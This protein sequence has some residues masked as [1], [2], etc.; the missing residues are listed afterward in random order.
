MESGG[1]ERATLSGSRGPGTRRE[2]VEER[3]AVIIGA[4]RALFL[5]QGVDK[6]TMRAV[7]EQAGIAEGT[8]YLYFKHKRALLDAVL[9]EFYVD[10]IEGAER[11]VRQVAFTK[12]RLRFL[13]QHHLGSVLGEWQMILAAAS[14]ERVGAHYKD[15]EVY[16]LNRRYVSVFDKVVK[17]GVDRG[18]IRADVPHSVVRD[19]FFGGLE[20]MFRSL[21]LTRKREAL[22]DLVDGLL[23]LV[24]DGAAIHD[25]PEDLNEAPAE[26]LVVLTERLERVVA[27]LES[28]DEGS[29]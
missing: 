1:D 20:Y 29:P 27:R 19:L 10:L 28:K 21:V 22:E 23:L 13:A 26:R 15:T 5:Q 8:V 2:R 4:A 16:R 18:E 6:T 3:E 24:L 25:R 9:R 12:G 17:E 11:G 7:A 14:P